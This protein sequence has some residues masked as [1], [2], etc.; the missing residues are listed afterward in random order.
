MKCMFCGNNTGYHGDKRVVDGAFEKLVGIKVE[1]YKIC[2]DCWRG[3]IL[4]LRRA[5]K[6]AVEKIVAE[7]A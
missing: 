6:R 4:P 5:G 3:L 2:A 1:D 7:V